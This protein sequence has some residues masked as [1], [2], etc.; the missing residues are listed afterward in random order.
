MLHEINLQGKTQTELQTLQSQITFNFFAPD[1]TEDMRDEMIVLGKSI[2]TC[3]PH[4]FVLADL[5]D[6]EAM[7]LEIPDH[8]YESDPSIEWVTCPEC[9]GEKWLEVEGNGWTRTLFSDPRKAFVYGS[10]NHSYTP[11]TRCHGHGEVLEPH[12]TLE[13][14]VVPVTSVEPSHVWLLAA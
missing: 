1:T 10:L 12:H 13:S 2:N 7:T 6:V 14:V 8:V 11:C 4:S 5:F 3:L 9:E